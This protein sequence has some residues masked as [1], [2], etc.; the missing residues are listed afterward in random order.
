MIS[1]TG[2]G[3]SDFLF[4]QFLANSEQNSFSLVFF[5]MRVSGSRH[6]YN[7]VSSESGITLLVL[8]WKSSLWLLK[9]GLFKACYNKSERNKF[10]KLVEYFLFAVED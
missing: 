8:N 5:R 1:I 2:G 4:S 6:T 3:C 10:M 7:F 9:R